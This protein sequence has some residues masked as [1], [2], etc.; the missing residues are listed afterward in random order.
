MTQGDNWIP[1]PAAAADRAGAASHP[2]TSPDSNTAS[3]AHP[4]TSVSILSSATAIAAGPR[5]ADLLGSWI[6][7][8]I[9]SD[10][11]G[12]AGGAPLLNR[13]APRIAPPRLPTSGCSITQADSPV[14][15]ATAA[16]RAGRTTFGGQIGEQFSLT[17]AAEPSCSRSP[18]QSSPRPPLDQR[19]RSPVL[20]GPEI[21]KDYGSE[22]SPASAERHESLVGVLSSS[23]TA[24]RSILP[25][26]VPPIWSIVAAPPAAPPSTS[27]GAPQRLVAAV[28]CS[29]SAAAPPAIIA[30][31]RQSKPT[32]PQEA[33]SLL[34][35]LAAP[36]I[37]PMVDRPTTPPALRQIA[38][39][40]VPRPF[41]IGPIHEQAP[42]RPPAPGRQSAIRAYGNSAGPAPVAP[43]GVSS[44]WLGETQESTS[45]DAPPGASSKSTSK[46]RNVLEGAFSD[47][48]V[49]GRAPLHPRPAA[50][51]QKAGSAE[52][53]R[54]ASADRGSRRSPLGVAERGGGLSSPPSRTNAAPSG[55]FSA[56]LRARRAAAAAAATAEGGSGV[57][58]ATKQPGD[59]PLRKPPTLSAGQVSVVTG[60][61]PI[62]ALGVAAMPAMRR[63][64]GG[65]GIASRVRFAD[66]TRAA[67]APVPLKRRRQDTG[68]SMLASATP[69]SLLVD[70]APS[71]PQMSSAAQKSRADDGYTSEELDA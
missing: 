42:I 38:A 45:P 60:R 67:D 9:P 43:A 4:S 49:H 21:H 69:A 10:S 50:A 31:A 64:H 37:T 1:S 14:P 27:C 41:R 62:A 16:A 40:A 13:D 39:A 65:G 48:G 17:L 71:P 66:D 30:P 5:P 8:A 63:A 26:D 18:Q 24:A 57:G 20:G 58:E 54:P 22:L 34:E 25:R 47:A 56:S 59:A 2:L 70:S 12:A 7:S 28:V 19:H 23:R 3:S 11:G 46:P 29:A 6:S 35:P 15:S 53:A 68:G 51:D 33:L 52:A 36:T 32:V 55:V 61:A 44:A